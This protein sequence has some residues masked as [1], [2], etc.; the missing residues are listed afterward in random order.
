MNTC[1]TFNLGDVMTQEVLAAVQISPNT[2][3]LSS[4]LKAPGDPACL[5]P[6][7]FLTFN[8][9]DARAQPGSPVPSPIHLEKVELHLR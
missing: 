6:E 7:A 4:R 5:H 2:R 8:L 9:G 1:L 3:I